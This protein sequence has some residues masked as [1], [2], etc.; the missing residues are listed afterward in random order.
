MCKFALG[1]IL[2][3]FSTLL[4][5]TLEVWAQASPFAITHVTV[6]DPASGKLMSD[7][8]IVVRGESIESI[9]PSKQVKLPALLGR[10]HS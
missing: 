8:T 3:V 2:V 1:R 4:F 9:V 6:I 5:I 10:S 7:M